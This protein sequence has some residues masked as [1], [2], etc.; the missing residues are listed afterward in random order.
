MKHTAPKKG[1]SIVLLLCMPL[2]VYSQK[3]YEIKIT[4]PS[5]KDSTI[6]LGHYLGN[7]KN[8]FPDDT[9]KL[10]QKGT[11]MFKGAQALAQGLY[12]I[13]VPSKGIIDIIVSENQHF[14]IETDTANLIKGVKFKN[15]PENTQLYTYRNFRESRWELISKLNKR[16]QP[17]T[18]ASVKDSI[19]RII[20]ET[21]KEV[22]RY[23]HEIISNN[24]GLFLAQFLKMLHDEE[25]PDYP[26]DANGAVLDSTFRYKYVRKHF[27]DN[28]NYT[29]GR[30]LRTP[31]YEQKLK[32][33][34]DN[35]V[36]PWP[37][38]INNELDIV[39]S[40]IKDKQDIFRYILGT[41]YIKYGNSQI[42]GQDA[43]MVHLVENWYFPHATWLDS[44]SRA[45]MT[46]IVN[47]LKHNLIGKIAPDLKLIEIPYDHFIV[48]QT[49]TALKRNVN[50]GFFTSLHAY[51]SK[52]LVVVFWQADCGHCK[53]AIP[54]LHEAYQ[55]LKSL[56]VEVLA[57]HCI[58]SEE[59][60]IK[61]VNFVNEHQLHDWHNAWS[62][63]SYEY[64]ELYN[65]Y[66]FPT[67]YVLDQNKKII[68]KRI[69]V[70]QIKD[71]IDME[72]KRER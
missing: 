28:F 8:L 14:G 2:F 16:V 7:E 47:K 1:I 63:M 57:I 35:I 50:A 22:D 40:H 17:D 70:D 48:A 59:G 69:G 18:S 23:A 71:F 67:L 56:G 41:F 32:Y 5:L 38:S 34:F 3:G 19:N 27:F 11:A 61:W 15:S 21:S 36:P 25:I 43:I 49:D 30:L 66:T 58:T 4:I 53:K 51:K 29:D 46:T 42:M 12:F 65:A 54:E 64:Q 9:V 13:Y 6:I 33:Y 72:N 52:F 44:T 68:A 24:P 39:L 62:P 31:L 20:G 60:K 37:D 55:Q 10:N 45:E 26:R